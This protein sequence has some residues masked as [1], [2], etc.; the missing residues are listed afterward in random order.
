MAFL[1]KGKWGDIQFFIIAY[2][3]MW[4]MTMIDR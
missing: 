4:M 3:C 2:V 1:A